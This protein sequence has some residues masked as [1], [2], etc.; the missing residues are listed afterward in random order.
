MEAGSRSILGYFLSHRIRIRSEFLHAEKPK[1]STDEFAM[2]IITANPKKGP[3][4]GYSLILFFH[5][6]CQVKRG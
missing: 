4:L 6:L 5:A 3:P 1:L 2:P